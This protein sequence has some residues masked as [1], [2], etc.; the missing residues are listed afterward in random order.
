MFIPKSGPVRSVLLVATNVVPQNDQHMIM[1]TQLDY[2]AAQLRG[3]GIHVECL[4]LSLIGTP[5]P[6]PRQEQAQDT[7]QHLFAQRAMVLSRTVAEGEFDLVGLSFRNLDP[8]LIQEPCAEQPI[9]EYYL[10]DLL[11]LSA[12][13]R[14]A[15]EDVFLVL[16]G[17]AYSLF[18]E[19]L[20]RRA[21]ADYGIVGAGEAALAGLVE[22]INQDRP[23]LD[24]IISRSFDFSSA[25]FSRG[26]IDLPAYH[27][28]GVTASLQ[29]KRGCAHQCNYC[30]YPALEGRHYQLR[31]ATVVVDEMEALMRTG[32][33]DF[34][35]LDAVFN[36]PLEQAKSILREIIRRQLDVRLEGMLSPHQ[37]DEEFLDL[38]EGA[39]FFKP[40]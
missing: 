10:S 26:N 8:S 5:F 29:T 13:V 24:R 12:A 15:N 4:D 11:E 36:S 23:P 19:T 34:Y 35:F 6:L 1:P 7:F 30:N 16:G 18:P 9:R 27:K 31:P 28:L 25:V 22:S 2:L 33:E 21:R 17:P 14:Q 39:G 20:L 40:L 3:R 32:F 37:L 38:A